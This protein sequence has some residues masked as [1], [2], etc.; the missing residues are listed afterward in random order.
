MDNQ[1]MSFS[2]LSS[3][4]LYACEPYLVDIEVDLSRGLNA[5]SIVGMPDKAIEEAKDR[6]SAAIKNSG[7]TSP[8][9][10]N[11][12][13]VISLAPAELRKEGSNFDLAMALAYLLSSD[14]IRFN[15]SGKI[16]LGELSL[17]GS[18]RPI[19]GTLPLVIGAKK[20]G[21]KEIYIPSYNKEE[22]LLVEGIKVFPVT[23]LQ[24]VCK[25]LEAQYN[26]TSETISPLIPQPFQRKKIDIQHD[27]REI[28]GQEGAK[29]A[30]EIAAAGSHNIMLY[31]PPG[32]GKTMLARAFAFLLPELSF[33]EILEVS[34]IHSSVK[35][36][37]G[38][39]S[40]PPFRAPHHSASYVSMV[41]G[42]SFPKPGEVTLAH[43]G[44]L[45]MD[46]FP[47]FDLR[48]IDSLRQPLEDK[49][50][51]ISRSKHSVTFPCNFILVASMNP[52]PCGFRGSR[53]KE[54]ICSAAVVQ[55]YQQKIS[56]P[57]ID[58]IDLWVE[59][60]EIDYKKLGGVSKEESTFLISSRVRK[61]YV[62]KRERASDPPL[63]QA[64][65]DLLNTSAK[66][67]TLSARG[68]YKI[69]NVARTIADLEGKKD[70]E[71]PHILEALQYRPKL[72]R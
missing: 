60:A 47:E 69:L 46:E 1:S 36:S 7:F 62:I 55:K 32:T 28:K 70:V 37:G 21:I 11:H 17:D 42:G 8:K 12:K 31:G 54:C 53:I 50:V 22:A 41:G 35:I 66:A 19:K 13:V 24:E 2:K 58:R 45:F 72:F 48:V 52:C 39:I 49:W 34:A 56:G 33:E 14:D 10:K 20:K 71:E 25:H 29:R 4:Q 15:P 67:M 51:T 18:L 57:I 16:F 44:V 5:F 40:H 38:I 30:L 43:R 65:T 6:V 61:A 68:Y 63:S 59:V 3:M 27:F 9:S 23:H 64:C 26:K